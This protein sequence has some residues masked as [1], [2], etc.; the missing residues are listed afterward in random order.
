[1]NYIW[2]G[3]RK[4]ASFLWS[5]FV[6]INWKSLGNSFA[7]VLWMT[8]IAFSPLFI[9]ILIAAS[10]TNDLRGAFIDKIIPGEM[11][12]Y[13]MSFL[14]PSLYLLVKT[15]G[16]GYTVPLFKYFSISTYFIYVCTVVLYLAAKNNWVTDVDMQH[17]PF[18]I[19][20]KLSLTFLAISVLFRIFS[21]YHG[22]F[23]NWTAERKQ[24]QETFNKSLAERLKTNE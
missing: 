23:S 9:N 24:Q 3:I 21:I 2:N 18:G 11:L 10:S 7:E 4:V 19:F 12:S 5:P 6:D 16:S 17:H 8:L 22:G 20:F 14:A 15:H 13:C 1:M